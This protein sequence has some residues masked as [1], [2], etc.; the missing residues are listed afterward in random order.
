MSNFISIPVTGKDNFIINSNTVVTCVRTSS[1]TTIVVIEGGTSSASAT[2]QIEVIHAADTAADSVATSIMNGVINSFSY[3]PDRGVVRVVTPA[4]AISSINFSGSSIVV[5]DVT[6]TLPITS[7]GGTTP[8]IGINAATPSTSGSM[9]ASDKTKLDGIA[10]GAEVNVNSDWNATSGDAEILN[11]PTSWGNYAQTVVSAT[12]NTAPEQS[13]IGTGVGSLS[14]PANAFSVG[15]SFHGKMGGLINA[16]GGGGRSEI[17]IR[18]K[19]GATVLASTGVF[20]L[21]NATNQGWEIELDFTIA[22][23]GAAGSICTNGNFAYTK[24]GSRQVFGYIF[25]DVQPIDTTISNTLD[26]TVEWNVLN[27]GDDI[28]SANFV[29]YKVY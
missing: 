10:T 23:I 13:I 3:G 18:I 28:Y 6:A 11:K 19:T 29:L 22:T 8:D 9:S 25:Q 20:D 17:T 24:N 2:D 26:I 7:T 14:I 1:T 4:Q 27:G 5:T 12:I 15:D 21:D 16:T